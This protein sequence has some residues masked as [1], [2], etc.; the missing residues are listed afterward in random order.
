MPGKSYF[1][2]IFPDHPLPWNPKPNIVRPFYKHGIR[3]NPEVNCRRSFVWRL[4]SCRTTARYFYRNI[5]QLPDF[6][7]YN[8][9]GRTYRY[10]KG[11]PLFP[12]GYGLSYTTFLTM[13]TSNWSKRLKVGET[14][15]MVIPVTN[16][17][18]RDGKK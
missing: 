5:T 6:E 3:D 1:S 9:T 4:Q 2:L 15:K 11:D 12:F 8:M 7:D 10:F 14:A 18:N 17:G 13:V 16:T